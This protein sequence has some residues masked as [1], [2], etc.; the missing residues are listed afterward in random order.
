MNSDK[1][2]LL[3][4]LTMVAVLALGVANAAPPAIGEQEW[5]SAPAANYAG[6]GNRGGQ[7]GEHF[8]GRGN[9]TSSRCQGMSRGANCITPASRKDAAR[10]AAAARAESGAT[11]PKS[12]N[13]GNG[14]NKSGGKGENEI[15][16]N[17]G[18]KK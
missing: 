8:Q 3:A 17:G 7:W 5:E 12:M 10:R 2:M 14:G 4:P 6:Q 9:V 15:R 16:G 13:R 18:N 1:H 11:I